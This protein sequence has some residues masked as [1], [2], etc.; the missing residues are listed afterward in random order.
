MH[1]VD[2]YKGIDIR[3]L[4]LKKPTK[5]SYNELAHCNTWSKIYISTQRNVDLSDNHKVVFLKP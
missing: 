5:L 1:V 2:I 3:R 4:P